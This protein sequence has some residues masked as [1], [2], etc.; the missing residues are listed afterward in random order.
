MLMIWILLTLI[1]PWSVHTWLVN[2]FPKTRRLRVPLAVGLALF[3][4]SNF[5]LSWWLFRGH[6]G[7][8]AALHLIVITTMISVVIAL[9]PVAAYQVIFARMR[10]PKSSPPLEPS[11]RM[12]RREFTEA[13]AG[14]TL[15]AATGASLVWGTVRGRREF[16][17]R[18]L[19]IKVSGLP[20]VLDGYTMVQ[21]SDLHTGSVAGESLLA[22]GL[23]VV[24]RLKPDLV[25]VTGDLVD[26]DPLF[27]P[28]VARHLAAITARD[29]VEVVL[30]NH[31]YFAGHEKV[32]HALNAVGLNPLLNRGKVIRPRDG[33]GFALLGVEDLSA[34]NFGAVGPSLE[35][36][37]SFVPADLPRIL[38]SHQ[39]T[40][41]LKWSGQV[42]LQL[43]G[44]TH[45]GQIYAGALMPDMLIKFIAGHYDV[46]NTQLYV[47]RG[48]GTVGPP[49]RVGVP[50]EVT[51]IVLVPA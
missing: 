33:G 51:R 41:V 47:N 32:T 38:L 2:C 5:P 1:A 15:L 45:G 18:E 37:L 13:T 46:G 42:D 4:L 31:D 34:K 24:N 25:V 29:G 50:P 26:Y 17:V 11:E 20:R 3:S 12:S 8:A 9:S 40:S 48:L 21:I 28:M 14:V 39:P 7:L 16:E 35:R 36:A 44:H 30:G 23:S 10:R 43:S 27:A 19:E 6:S 49:S 22:E